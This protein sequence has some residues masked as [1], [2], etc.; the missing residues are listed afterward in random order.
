MN[1]QQVIALVTPLVAAVGALGVQYGLVNAEQLTLFGQL[2]VALVPVVFTIGA[3]WA[4]IR[5]SSKKNQV[6]SV[7]AMNDVTRVVMT[8]DEA[9]AE[10]PASNVVGPS[11]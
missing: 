7:A 11:K 6:A 5:S 10:H 9:A 2:A 4:S 3:V 1:Q 8:T